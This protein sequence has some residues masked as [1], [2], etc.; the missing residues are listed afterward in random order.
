MKQVREETM[1]RISKEA[2]KRLKIRAAKE[3]ITIKELLEILSKEK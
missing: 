1:T 2:L 3:G